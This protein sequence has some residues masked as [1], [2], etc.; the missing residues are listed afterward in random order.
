LVPEER[1]RALGL[2]E[3]CPRG[4][5][6]TEGKIR[7]DVAVLWCMDL[8]SVVV[9]RVAELTGVAVVVAAFESR[10]DTATAPD[11]APGTVARTSDAAVDTILARAVES[12]SPKYVLGDLVVVVVAAADMAAAVSTRRPVEAVVKLDL[13]G[14]SAEAHAQSQVILAAAVAVYPAGSMLDLKMRQV[15]ADPWVTHPFPSR[16]VW[17]LPLQ[18][19][20]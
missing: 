16:R 15:Q 20:S 8:G 3:S 7:D 9:R 14:L 12:Q 19:V 2:R 1:R 10:A 4:L 6:R 17:T 5:L 11:M 13:Y 18:S